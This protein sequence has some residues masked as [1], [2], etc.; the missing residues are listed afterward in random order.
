MIVLLI[1]A[2]LLQLSFWANRKAVEVEGPLRIVKGPQDTIYIQID[3]KIVKTSSEGDVI[4]IVDLDADA[5]IPEPIADFFVEDDGGL[6]IARTESQLLQYYSSEGKLLRTHLRVPSTVVQGEHFCKFTKD[7]ATGNLYFADTSHHRIQMYG[8]DEKEIK[9]ILVPS[10][11][12]LSQPLPVAEE[13]SE[14]E[15]QEFIPVSPDKP[16]YYPNGLVFDRDR[17]IAT[18]TG[19]SR[20]ILFYPDGS[21]DKIIPV[22]VSDPALSNP[23]RV[24]RADDTVYVVVRGPNF[25]GGIVSAFDQVTGAPRSF[26]HSK[27]MD[28]WDVLAR[29]EDILIADRDSLSVLSFTRNGQLVGPFGKES[30]QS[31]YAD[32]QMSRSTFE[33][34]RKGSLV[35]MVLILGWLFLASRRQ[36]IAH[37]EAG[38]SLFKPVLA[39]QNFLGPTGSS[40]RKLLLLVPGLGQAAAGRLLR[41]FTLLLILAY[42]L[43]SLG[44][45]WYQYLGKTSSPEV[46][47]AVALMNFTVWTAIVID[48]V[49]ITRGYDG[50]KARP[51][52]SIMLGNAAGPLIIILS[53]VTAQLLWEIV[54]F[55]SPAISRGMQQ[56]YAMIGIKIKYAY[57]FSIPLPVSAA[58]SW[59]A[60]A[61]AIFGLIASKEGRG[62]QRIMVSAAFGFLTGMISWLIPLSAESLNFGWLFIGVTIQGAFVSIMMYLYFRKRNLPLLIIPAGIAGS[63][64]GAFLKLLM[65]GFLALVRNSFVGH[66]FWSGLLLQLELVLIPALFMYFAVL[67]ALNAAGDQDMLL[68]ESQ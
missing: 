60:S 2:G 37:E 67:F 40:R 43:A 57:I 26:T 21:L 50:K 1:L 10:G 65:D 55:W 68:K 11:V 61:A 38:R 3:R 7:S 22:S 45:A 66:P 63:C 13:F 28:P 12:S 48:G 54:N 9:T 24:S 31:L 53:A 25:F 36:R 34:M 30:L 56:L 6:L 4:R 47:L 59:G 20:I 33:W 32:R 39:I 35:S 41:T 17:L 42:F 16:L 23:F 62:N 29:S 8:P 49:R 14:A 51:A 5:A 15:E 18:D 52:L 44:Y 58:F 19:N 46:F 64:I 27:T